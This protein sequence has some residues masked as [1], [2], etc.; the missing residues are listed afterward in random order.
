M[1]SRVEILSIGDV[2]TDAFIKLDPKFVRLDER[3]KHDVR[4]SI[5]YGA[6]IPFEEVV[7]IPGVGNA[8]NAAVSFARLGLKSALL[9]HVGRDDYGQEILHTLVKNNV[10][11]QFIHSDP[12]KFTN[13]HYVLWFESDR[14]ILMKHEKYDWRLPHLSELDRPRWIYLS[15]LGPDTLAFHHQIGAFIAK[16]SDIK[17]VFQPDRFQ[18]EFGTEE[19]AS[20]YK[21]AELVFCNREEAMLITKSKSDDVVELMRR[22]HKLGPHQAVITDGP[23]G[24][25]GSDGTTVWSMRNYPDPAAPVDRTGAGDAF[26]STVTAAVAHGKS[27]DEAMV[28][29]PINSMSVVQGVGAQAGLLSESKI[30]TW[31]S[32]APAD[33]KPKVIGKI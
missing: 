9:A 17:L 26:A 8:A 7:I 24:S 11:T 1:K 13:Y 12:G 28:W 29:A 4:L 10:Q 3:Q 5:P 15:R 6:K 16:N 27:L 19:L 31:L 2:L 30:K 23:K 22:M 20:I 14:T 18:M 21:Y 32:K 25:Y 33:Y